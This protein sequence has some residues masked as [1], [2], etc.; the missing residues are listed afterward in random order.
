MV[1][2]KVKPH[3]IVEWWGANSASDSSSLLWCSICHEFSWSS[4][5][6]YSI[7]NRACTGGYQ[8]AD[9]Y[10]TEETLLRLGFV[11]QGNGAVAFTI[12]RLY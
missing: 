6:Y 8:S 5:I 9:N 7:V 10:P 12:T 3:S 1:D 4:S 11:K 2:A